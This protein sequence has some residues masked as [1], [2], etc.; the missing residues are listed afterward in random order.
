LHYVDIL[1]FPGVAGYSIALLGICTHNYR[2]LY[3]VPHVNQDLC[4]KESE[5]LSKIET[6]ANDWQIPAVS[7]CAFDPS[8]DKKSTTG[9][10]TD[11]RGN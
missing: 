5:H 10:F 7:T 9:S 11:I 8:F 4:A 3:A 1:T 2:R 6:V